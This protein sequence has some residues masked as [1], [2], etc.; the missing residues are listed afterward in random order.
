MEIPPTKL[1]KIIKS[2]KKKIKYF[3]NKN[4]RGLYHAMN[5]GIKKSKGDIIGILNQMNIYILNYNCQDNQ[6]FLF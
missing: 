2:Y 6:L 3:R 4:D 5:V 1:L